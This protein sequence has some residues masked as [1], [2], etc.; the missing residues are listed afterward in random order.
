[1]G[2]T[3]ETTGEG[4][5]VTADGGAVMTTVFVQPAVTSAATTRIEAA[6]RDPNLLISSTF[7][8]GLE[9]DPQGN[10]VAPSRVVRGSAGIDR[11]VGAA[12]EQREERTALARHRLH[13][14]VE[15]LVV[16]VLHDLR[17]FVGRVHPHERME[18]LLLLVAPALGFE[19]PGDIFP[20]T[21]RVGIV[22]DLHLERVV[23]QRLGDVH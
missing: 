5:A 3:D 1:M 14:A 17:S 22:G 21:S 4:G 9:Y 11:M 10:R 19:I 15:P 16:D 20:D 12:R 8:S 18:T 7:D 2:N 6:R 23:P 13:P